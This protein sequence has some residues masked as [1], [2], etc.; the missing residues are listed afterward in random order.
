MSRKKVR[1]FC[2]LVG[3]GVIFWLAVQPARAQWYPTVNDCFCAQPVP[4]PVCRTVPVTEYRQVRRIVRKP[5]IEQRVVEQPVTEYRPVVETRTVDVQTIEYQDVV[6]CRTVQ[7]Q[8][9]YW[10]VRWCPVPRVSPC[11]YDSRP[12]LLGFLNRL[13]YTIQMTLTPPVVPVAQYVPQTIVRTVPVTRR[14]AI[15]KTRKVTYNVTRWVPYTTTKKVVMNVV[16]YLDE[17]VVAWEPVT[18][19]RTVPVGTQLAYTYTPL[20][21]GP[22]QTTLVPQPDPISSSS[23]SKTQPTRTATSRSHKYQQPSSQPLRSSPQ[24]SKPSNRVP[25]QRSSFSVPSRPGAAGPAY[26]VRRTAA[27]TPRLAGLPSVIRVSRWQASR[28]RVGTLP[29]HDPSPL[30]VADTSP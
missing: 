28:Q 30:S 9:G 11:E 29:S 16:K 8:T 17:E 21:V 6:E 1:A 12:D 22:A 15:P 27:A 7:Y 2:A 23:G 13:G 14:I 5:V 24:K 20:V 18:V 3:V 26:E 10:Q 4:Q 25:A 19:W